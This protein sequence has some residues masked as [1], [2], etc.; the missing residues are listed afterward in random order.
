LAPDAL[1]DAE[2]EAEERL[3]VGTFVIAGGVATTNDDMGVVE[4][5]IS[6]E[7]V[8]AGVVEIKGVVVVVNTMT[9][10]VGVCETTAEVATD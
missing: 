4:E 5:M 6:L 2:A 8:T 9:E 10:T 3:V 7:D 1:A